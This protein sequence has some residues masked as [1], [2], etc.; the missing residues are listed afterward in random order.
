MP[1]SPTPP[2]TCSL[3]CDLPLNISD[4]S[5]VASARHV[6][7]RFDQQALQ[8]IQ[9]SHAALLC[10][11]DAG[12]PI[13]GVT[14]GFGPFVAYP[15]DPNGNQHGQG[16]LAHLL[17]GHGPAAP[18]AVVRATMLI[19]ARSLARGYSGIHLDIAQQLLRLIESDIHPAIPQVGSVGASGDLTPLAYI[20]QVLTGQG[21]VIDSNGNIIDATTALQAAKLKPVKLDSRDALA[22]VNG[23]SF[24]S[25]YLAL[26]ANRM[27]QLLARAEQLTGWLYRLLGCSHQAIDARLHEARGHDGQ[28]ESARNIRN[29]AMRSTD[30]K[31]SGGRGQFRG[32]VLQ[33]VYSIR[34]APQVLGA[35]RGQWQYVCNTAE[36]E[37]NGVNDNPLIYPD[38]RTKNVDVLHGGNFQGQQI[39]FASDALNA[40]MTQTAV[41]AER[42]IAVLANPQL[43]DGAPLL[44]APNPGA[45]SGLAG[46]QLT[47]TAILADMRHAA[48][49]TAF[50]SIPTNGNNQDIV[51]MGTAAARRAYEQTERLAAVLGTLAIF[52]SQ[53][54]GLRQNRLCEATPSPKPPEFPE[55]EALLETDRP[56]RDDIQRFADYMLKP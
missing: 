36:T 16:L 51:S 38:T 15:A 13:Y 31:T 10:A 8:A 14:T 35:C 52:L 24:M 23:T 42:Q 45:T 17:T 55:F 30:D 49:P 9:Q 26:A 20:A 4:I 19:R 7:V 56:L 50:G 2:I 43:T 6:A 54:D 5:R 46:V 40:A 48:T 41:L 3:G 12:T 27:A 1:D 22:L 34:C 25:A 32:R 33:E 21:E 37:I 53:L 44:L 47:A 29:E 28:C 11:I 39:A 18:V